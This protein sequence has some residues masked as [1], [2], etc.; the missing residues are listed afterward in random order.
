MLEIVAKLPR[1]MAAITRKAVAEVGGCPPPSRYT[2]PP[3]VSAK[4]LAT[5]IIASFRSSARS[6]ASSGDCGNRTEHEEQLE[7]A[8]DE[9]SVPDAVFT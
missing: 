4:F 1:W 8:G 3:R 7:E 6:N 2:R 5:S 9:E